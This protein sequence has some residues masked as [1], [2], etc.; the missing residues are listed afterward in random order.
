MCPRPAPSYRITIRSHRF[1]KHWRPRQPHSSNIPISRFSP[2]IPAPSDRGRTRIHEPP[3]LLKG[4]LHCFYHDIYGP[5]PVRELQNEDVW[6]QCGFERPPS[7]RTLSRFIADFELVAEDVFIELV[8]E[9][10][11]RHLL[12]KFFRIDGTDIPVD[13]SCRTLLPRYTN[14]A[15]LT[16]FYLPCVSGQGQ[17]PMRS[18]LAHN[19]LAAKQFIERFETAFTTRSDGSTWP[20]FQRTW[21]HA[22]QYF[23]ALVRPGSGKSIAELATRV[24]ADQERLERFV[25]ESPWQP[26]NVERHLQAAA[27]DR[28]QGPD[29]AVIVD[30]MGIPKQGDHSVG[31]T[32][33]YCGA[34]GGVDNCQVTINCTLAQP[35]Q[36][37]NSDQVTWPLGSRLYLP[38]EW[39]GEDDSVYDDQH[40]QQRYT[41]LR[42]D[43]EI[44]E[45]ISHQPKYGIAA[46]LIERVV[47]AGVDHACVLGDS[48]FGRRSSFRER[49]RKLA[50]PYVLEIETGKLHVV[51]E[52]ADV[53]EP[54]PTERVIER[55]T[56]FCKSPLTA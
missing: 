54:G 16:Q 28:C 38:K 20:K 37:R 24:G 51:P 11:E 5:R 15:C 42:E 55:F 49:L 7:R 8:H 44:P 19:Q 23:R 43:V 13:W 1:S 6:R 30:G 47:D 32:D 17:F 21:K 29:A 56:W 53:L 31:V 46:D 14:D 52:S 33:Q 2:T 4:V 34:S 10:A 9:L 36:Y 35:G 40:Q 48:N 18:T 3:E 39:T 26:E 12:G 45:S 22:N 25:R 50:E 41:Q 27:P